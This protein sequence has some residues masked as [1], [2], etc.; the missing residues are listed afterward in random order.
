MSKLRIIFSYLFDQKGVL[1][2]LD[3]LRAGLNRRVSV[4]NDIATHIA[5]SKAPD[6]VTLR[7]W[8]IELGVPEKYRRRA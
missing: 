7:S 4:E 8:A 6:L 1:Q 2:E 3:V 5:K